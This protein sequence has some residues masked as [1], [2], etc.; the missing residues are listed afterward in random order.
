MSGKGLLR[1]DTKG[2]R[3]LLN[4]PGMRRVVAAEASR[5]KQVAGPGHETTMSKGRDR[6]RSSVH[7]ATP[8]AKKS[9]EKHRTLTKAAML[10]RFK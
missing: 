8:E 2:V 5:M 10:A 6:Y 4:E 3:Q 1:L 9:E 7:T